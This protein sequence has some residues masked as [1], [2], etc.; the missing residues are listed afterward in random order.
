ME[1]QHK[2]LIWVSFDA[3]LYIFASTDANVLLMKCQQTFIAIPKH[4][5]NVDKHVSHVRYGIR[6]QGV[7][8]VSEIACEKEE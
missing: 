4:Q 6:V 5:Y 7:P 3:R 8:L 2:Q 1:T